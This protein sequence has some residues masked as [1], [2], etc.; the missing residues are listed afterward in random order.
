MGRGL[1]TACPSSAFVSTRTVSSEPT[2]GKGVDEVEKAAGWLWLSVRKGGNWLLNVQI[3][4]EAKSFL[5]DGV[6][7]GGRELVPLSGCNFRKWCNSGTN[8]TPS[9]S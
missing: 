6:V 1:Q 2:S 7:I 5:V 3:F 4:K 8:S 9:D